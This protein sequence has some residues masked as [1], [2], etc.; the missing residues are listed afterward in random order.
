[1]TCLTL[2]HVATIDG[3]AA[4]H[5]MSLPGFMKHLPV[6]ESADLIAA[7]GGQVFGIVPL[8]ATRGLT[9]RDDVPS[10]AVALENRPTNVARE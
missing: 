2:M 5:P 9:H 8:P 3:L 6:L 1:M 10:A 7:P 4:P